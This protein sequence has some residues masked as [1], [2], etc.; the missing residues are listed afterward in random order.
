MTQAWLDSK[1]PVIPVK[2][3]RGYFLM[4]DVSKCRDLIPEKYF[5]PGNYED[6]E[7]TKIVQRQ[8]TE[9]VPLDYAFVRWMC[10]EIGSTMQPGICFQ[11]DTPEAD[12]H[13]VRVAICKTPDVI[14][15]VKEKVGV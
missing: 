9:K 12:D 8:F 1:Y 11:E 7:E 14:E 15:S 6:D 4:L 5:V 13:F 10:I 3:E 2:A